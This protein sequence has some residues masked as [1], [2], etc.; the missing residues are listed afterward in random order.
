MNAYVLFQILLSKLHYEKDKLEKNKGT[1]EQAPLFGALSSCCMMNTDMLCQPS[2]L[3]C[4]FDTVPLNDNTG[5]GL[6]MRLLQELSNAVILDGRELE[7]V[8]FINIFRL[9][10][11]C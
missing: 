5:F 4:W 8:R 6:D 1:N 11:H 7:S 9:L 2:G 10:T 3:S